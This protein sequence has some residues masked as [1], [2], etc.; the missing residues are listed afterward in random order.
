ADPVDVI[1]APVID[2]MYTAFKFAEMMVDLKDLAGYPA[3]SRAGFYEK[4][5]KEEFDGL[6]EYLSTHTP[7]EHFYTRKS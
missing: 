3:V 5:P 2:P 4:Q 6:R 7:P 1:G